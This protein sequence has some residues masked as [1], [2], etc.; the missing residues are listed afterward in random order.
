[1]VSTSSALRMMD[2]RVFTS[3]TVPMMPSTSRMSPTRI[4]R[5]AST[6]MP[7]M[8]FLISVCMPKP[9]PMASAPP[10]KAK[11]VSGILRNDKVPMARNTATPII[12]QLRSMRALVSARWPR[13]TRVA[14]MRLAIFEV[15]Q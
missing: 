5:S 2:E 6:M 7:L 11:I 10:K 12:N 14:W 4:L 9:K 8:K 15:I 3:A 1:M 13:V